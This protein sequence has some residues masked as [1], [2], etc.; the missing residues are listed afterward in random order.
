MITLDIFLMGLLIVSTLTGVV[1]EAVKKMLDSTKV[2]YNSN[3]IAAIVAVV[4]AAGVGVG[5]TLIM[6]LG[7]SVQIIACIVALVFMSWLCSMIGYDKV[8]QII[9]SLKTAKKG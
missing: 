7:F 6:G 2:K 8:V 1:T 4:L 9:A 3:I 5:Y